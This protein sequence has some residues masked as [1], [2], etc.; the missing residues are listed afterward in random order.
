MDIHT[1]EQQ[2]KEKKGIGHE[3]AKSQ[4]LKKIRSIKGKK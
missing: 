3:E 2:L 1:A 4:V